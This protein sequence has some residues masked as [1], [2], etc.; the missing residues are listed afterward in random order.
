MI[1]HGNKRYCIGNIVDG[2]VRCCMVTVDSY[3]CDECSITYR[4]VESLCCTPE[5]NITLCVKYTQK[6]GKYLKN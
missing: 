6:N 1:S 3:T 4:D 2:I 5:T